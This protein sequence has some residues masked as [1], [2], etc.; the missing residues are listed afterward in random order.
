MPGKLES[1]EKELRFTRSRQAVAFWM[2][3]AICVA[4]AVTL[5]ATSI[6]RAEAPEIPHPAWALLPLT[7]AFFC[8]RKAIH[9]TRH[10]YLILTPLGI[11]IF[12]FF[13]PADGMRLVTWQEI[14][15]AEVDENLTVLT[16]HHDAA[17]TSGIH[18]SLSP[19]QADRRSLLAKAVL[20][21]LTP[22]AN[23]D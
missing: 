18:L 1:P 21:R 11:E 14:G 6:Y 4:V 15:A 7:G 19:I 3:A 2:A 10:A 17:R 13:K 5:L 9:L 12:P 16:L 22:P 20:G 23:P 8:C